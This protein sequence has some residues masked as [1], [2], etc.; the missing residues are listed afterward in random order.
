MIV[1]GS[2]VFSGEVSE[3]D[4]VSSLPQENTHEDC[5]AQDE[6]LSKGIEYVWEKLKSNRY[7]EESCHGQQAVSATKCPGRDNRGDQETIYPQ[8]DRWAYSLQGKT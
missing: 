8:V 5:S 6:M 4:N 2:S 7:D 3:T 1:V